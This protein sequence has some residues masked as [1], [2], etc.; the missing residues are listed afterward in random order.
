MWFGVA[1]VVR[2]DYPADF[3][4][5]LDDGVSEVRELRDGDLGERMVRAGGNFW[6]MYAQDAGHPRCPWLALDGLDIVVAP[7]VALDLAVGL[8]G[9]RA[10]LVGKTSDP[11]HHPV[12]QAGTLLQELPIVQLGS[13]TTTHVAE[14]TE[15]RPQETRGENTGDAESDASFGVGNVFSGERKCN[16]GE[17]EGNVSYIPAF[18]AAVDANELPSIHSPPCSFPD[19]THL[20][21]WLRQPRRLLAQEEPE[22]QRALGLRER[23]QKRLGRR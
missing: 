11:V 13:Y 17:V 14:P 23:L 18:L 2:V 4:R 3:D 20:I 12:H 9:T 7:V 8:A 6:R 1:I 10:G 21:A 15:R 19:L 22:G 5:V 16:F